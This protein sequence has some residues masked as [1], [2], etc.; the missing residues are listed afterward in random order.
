MA[1]LATRIERMAAYVDALRE[2]AGGRD[3][4]TYINQNTHAVRREVLESGCMQLFTLTP[5]P[6][7]GGLIQRNIDPFTII[8]DAPYGHSII[9]NLID[10]IE[11]AIGV[12]SEPGYGQPQNEASEGVAVEP[13]QKGY[14]FIAMPMAGKN[15]Q[16]D[17]V[18]DAI[19]EVARQCGLTAERVDDAESNDR[20]TDR[21]L[22]SIRKAEFVVV[23]LTEERPNVFYEA[24]YAQG[25]GKTPI[26]LAREGTSLHFDLKDYPVIFFDSLRA[27]KVKLEKRLRALSG[28]RAAS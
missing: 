9:P 20:I 19:K 28:A 26:Y 1:K 13:I 17:D 11:R 5:P 14:V 12:M 8:F 24:G 27:L 3:R 7:I 23:D 2:V 10:M 16:M 25:L 15:P 6:A 4:R 18:H 21:L 22:E